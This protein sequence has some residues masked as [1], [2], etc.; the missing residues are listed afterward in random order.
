MYGDAC[1]H[2]VLP[3]QV[4]RGLPRRRGLSRPDSSQLGEVT[5]RSARP[6]TPALL[7]FPC[8][9]LFW[10]GGGPAR[11]AGRRGFCARA[12]SQTSHAWRMMPPRS[13]PSCMRERASTAGLFPLADAAPQALG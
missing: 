8:V 12:P 11:G 4:K 9:G 6:G 13:A 3:Q 10:G 1:A 7:C 2:G 5:P